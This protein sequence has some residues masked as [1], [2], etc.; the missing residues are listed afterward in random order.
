MHNACEV[1][2][3]RCSG[4]MQ[5][6]VALVKLLIRASKAEVLAHLFA[7]QNWLASIER[8]LHEI[9]AFTSRHLTGAAQCAPGRQVARAER[10]GCKDGAV[11]RPRG[12]LPR[13]F[14]PTLNSVYS[15][16]FCWRVTCFTRGP[17]PSSEK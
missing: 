2:M 12:I 8:K 10:P 7:E 9:H 3:L 4:T 16:R 13:C 15:T 11:L 14:L 1:S 17:C 5:R 6:K